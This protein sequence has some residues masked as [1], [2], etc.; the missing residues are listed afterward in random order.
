MKRVGGPPIHT[1]R[2]EV[3]HGVFAKVAGYLATTTYPKFR[4]LAS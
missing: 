1:P 3:H 2:N 4:W